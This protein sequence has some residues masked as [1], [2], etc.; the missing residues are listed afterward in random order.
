[1]VI[2]LNPADKLYQLYLYFS[3]KT[4]YKLQWL[5]PMLHEYRPIRRSRNRTIMN[6]QSVLNSGECIPS[7]MRRDGV[8][9]KN[10]KK[11]IDGI[12]RWYQF[13]IITF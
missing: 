10:T 7:R 4:K 9:E 5:M 3:P 11:V 6:V 13:A 12:R 1:L 8:S 2:E